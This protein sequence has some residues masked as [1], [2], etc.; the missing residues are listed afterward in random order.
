MN[1]GKVILFSFIFVTCMA[2]IFPGFAQEKGEE[3]ASPDRAITMDAQYTGIRVPQDEEVDM[4]LIFMNKGKRG[5]DVIVWVDKAP[6]GWETSIETYQ[7]EVTGIHVPADKEKTLTFKATP[8]DNIKPG[9]Y[10]FRIEAKTEDGIFKMQEDISV[11]V[12]GKE[13]KEVKTSEK[14]ELSTFYPVL[15]GPVKGEFKFT[16]SVKNKLDREA[17]FNLF[18]SGPEKWNINFKP[19]FESTYVSSLR[20]QPDQTKNID[21]EVKPPLSAEAGEYPFKI[22]VSTEGAAAEAELK[23]ILTGSY[24]LKVSTASGLL[25]LDAK[26]GEKSNVSIYVRNTGTA[27]N[28]DITFTTFKPENWKVEF[29]P[30]RIDFIKPN[31]FKQVEVI[32]TPY[33]EALVGDYSIEIQ[34]KGEEGSQDSVEFRVT[35]KATPIWGWAGIGIIVFVIGGLVLTFRFLGRR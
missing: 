31:E 13:E 6:Q 19:A 30:E 28:K 20:L 16:V 10:F 25:S 7:F 1:W 29:K 8:P 5:E 24:D 33:K 2:V 12:I 22:R 15:S 17:V 3:T 4:D 27:E 18:A 14:I 26:P 9:K 23:V 35:V 34:A 11:E 32:I 21:V